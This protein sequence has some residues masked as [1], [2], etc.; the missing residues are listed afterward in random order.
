MPGHGIGELVGQALCGGWDS[1]IFP[2]MFAKKKFLG[3]HAFIMITSL[4]LKKLSQTV[5]VTG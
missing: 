1:V 2:S 5:D 4:C 3:L